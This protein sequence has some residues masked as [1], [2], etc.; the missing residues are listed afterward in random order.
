MDF[1]ASMTSRFVYSVH[2]KL[3]PNTT[4]SI[5]AGDAANNYWTPTRTIKTSP[6]DGEK[7]A[8]AQHHFL[9]IDLFTPFS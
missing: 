8:F 1:I 6:T 5:R 9:F 7:I 4:Y 3:E 2:L